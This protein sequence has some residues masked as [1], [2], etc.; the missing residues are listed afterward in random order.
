MDE[1]L[2]WLC[3]YCWKHNIGI[4]YINYMGSHDPS[5]CYEWP[6]LIIY[7]DQWYKPNEKPFMLAHEIGH[8]M[9]GTTICYSNDS[10]VKVNQS[11]NESAANK[12]AINLLQKY[13]DETD[14][15]FSSKYQFA[16][17]FGIPKRCFYLLEV[18]E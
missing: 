8:V 7:N 6:R 1:I 17:A 3:D 11:K 2:S 5:V 18:S 13:C 16:N 12:F 15:Y 10:G 14:I 9:C 4:Q